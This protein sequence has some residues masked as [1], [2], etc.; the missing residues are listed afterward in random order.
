MTEKPVI[1]EFV[2]KRKK[3]RHEPKNKMPNRKKLMWKGE[4]EHKIC[5]AVSKETMESD[6]S[7][8]NK[9]WNWVRKIKLYVNLFH[10][11]ASGKP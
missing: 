9:L 3:K 1:V 11:S 8:I 2:G 7:M 4:Y 6:L 10:R 5:G